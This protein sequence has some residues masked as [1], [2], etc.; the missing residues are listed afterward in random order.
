MPVLLGGGEFTRRRQ[1]AVN[2]GVRMF[3]EALSP[4]GVAGGRKLARDTA[5]VNGAASASL[6]L[7]VSVCPASTSVAV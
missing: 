1:I 6:R 7:H 3:L 5:V 4:R 2:F